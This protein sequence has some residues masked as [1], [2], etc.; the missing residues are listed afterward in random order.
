M[1]DVIVIG[2]GVAG[3]SA[4]YM[5]A[6]GG[7]KVLV[8]E[9]EKFPRYK[10]C[11]GGVVNRAVELLPFSIDAVS[12]KKIFNADIIDHENNL[13]FKVKREKPIIYMVMRADFDNFILSKA[14]GKGAI[15]H[16][17]LK[18]INLSNHKDFIEVK[19]SKEKYQ[20]RFVIAAD[21]AIGVAT[22]SLGI[23]NSNEKLPA[24]EIETFVNEN[25]FNMYKDS[26]RFDYGIIPS[27]YAWV[28]PKKEHLSIGVAIMKKKTKSIHY[29]LN[30][31]FETLCIRENDII[32]KEKHGY[33]IPI[34]SKM[35][36]YCCGRVFFAGD[37]LGLADPMTAE[38]ISYAIE[39]G[40][41]AAS[42]II[43]GSLDSKI[44]KR[45]YKDGLTQMFKELKGARFLSHFV[46][47]SKWIR[48]FVF[49]YFGERLSEMMT[50]V[51]MNKRKYSR[52]IINR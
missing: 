31:Y 11:G 13:H 51:I 14:V 22:K 26:A 20:A 21:G 38:G 44:A 5:L 47:D 23:K 52:F 25:T 10:T 19:T 35:G 1:Y 27:G 46:Y 7:L 24:I 41:M 8:I 33:L 28:F 3:T 12:E 40:Q 49:K 42:A 34:A 32:R 6:N 15:I 17:E 50:D 36:S 4:A 30:K 2:A 39:S 43:E 29:W 18:V 45:K 9:K 48:K 16:D 37:S